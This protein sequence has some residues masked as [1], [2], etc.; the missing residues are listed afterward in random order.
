MHVQVI[1]QYDIAG[2]Q[3]R[4]EDPTDEHSKDVRVDGP[5]HTQ[6]GY[7]PLEA[8]RSNYRQILARVARH[9]PMRPLPPW[10]PRVTPG[11]RYTCARFIH[12]NEPSLVQRRHNRP[13]GRPLALVAFTGA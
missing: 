5:L 13:K 10:R 1:Q 6:S 12:K 11:H 8:Q 9:D 7:H 4:D 3:S 2:P